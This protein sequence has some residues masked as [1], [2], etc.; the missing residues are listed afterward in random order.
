MSTILSDTIEVV[1]KSIFESIRLVLVEHGY[2]PDITAFSDNTSGK[3]LYQQAIDA[4]VVSKGFAIEL[5]GNSSSQKKYE[6][7]IPRIVI[8]PKRIIPG[9]IGGGPEPVFT[10]NGSTYTKAKQAPRTSTYE[11]EIG[12]TSN[13]A[14]QD[15]LLHSILA[16]SVPNRGYIKFYNDPLYDFYV[17][18][19]SFRESPSTQEGI[20]DKFYMFKALDL[21]IDEGQIISTTIVPINTISV[22]IE[23][24]KGIDDILQ[25]YGDI[26]PSISITIN[27]LTSTIG[28]FNISPTILTQG[29]DGISIV[30][31]APIGEIS[32]GISLPEIKTGTT[33]IPSTEVLSINTPLPEIKISVVIIPSMEVLSILENSPTVIISDFTLGIAVNNNYAISSNGTNVLVYKD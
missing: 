30:I 6:K 8:F 12:L 25:I 13:S 16:V 5:F 32:L 2:L 31:I 27:P 18:Q 14:Q 7:K 9:D 11:F 28:V 22:E 10:F 4:I 33:I 1:E 26:I 29:I 19:Y 20:N 23:N 15:R 3:A 21:Y 17:E 24:N